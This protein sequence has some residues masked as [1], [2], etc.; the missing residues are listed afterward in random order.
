MKPGSLLSA[1]SPRQV[2]DMLFAAPPRDSGVD[3]HGIRDDSALWRLRSGPDGLVDD[4]GT[5]GDGFER[6]S[7]RVPTL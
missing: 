6:T 4:R 3:R 5:Y 2:I 7:L 1:L